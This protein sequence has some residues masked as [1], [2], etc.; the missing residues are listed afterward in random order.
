MKR[1]FYKIMI[2]C[3][4]LVLLFTLRPPF[5]YAETSDVEEND[6][7]NSETTEEIADISSPVSVDIEV[8]D[9]NEMELVAENEYLELYFDHKNAEF[10]VKEK[11]NGH[12]WYSNPAGRAD[13]PIANPENKSLM[14]A[15]LAVQFF[16]N[17][18]QSAQFD[19]YKDSVTRDQ[20]T[21]ERIENGFEVVYEIGKESQN[22]D[23]IPQKISKERFESLILDKLSEEE[24][25]DIKKRFKYIEEE[26]LYERRDNAFSKLTLERTLD[27]FEKAGYTEEDVAYDNEEHGAELDEE[28]TD[29]SFIIPMRVEI[30]N[31]DLVV[32]I[33]GEKIEYEE[34]FPI[35]ELKVLPFFGAAGTDQE[36]YMLVP[37]GSGALI[38]LNNGKGRYDQFSQ[39]IYGRDEVDPITQSSRRTVSEAIRM[40]VFGMKQDNHAFFAVIEEGDA[41]G[42]I[43]AEVSGNIHSYN[44]ISSSFIIKQSQEITLYG[45]DQSNT[46]Y[47]IQKGEFND[48]IKIRYSF[49]ENEEANYTGMA[50]HYRQYLVD[51]YNLEPLN[52]KSMPFYLELTGA[53]IK[54]KS[55]LGV[56]YRALHPLTTFEQGEEIVNEL[57]GAN[58]DN[59]K[60]RYTGWFNRGVNH[61]IPT[62][63]KVDRVLGGEKGLEQ[64]NEFLV[65]NNL[66]LY[67]D[68]AFSIVYRNSFG[69]SPTRHASRFISREVAE[70]TPINPATFRRNSERSP[71][72]LLS[73]NHLARSIEG[74]IGDYKKL[75]IDHLSLRD[76]GEKIN[77]DYRESKVISREQSKLIF[78]EQLSYIH[79]NVSNL[80]GNGGNAILFPYAKDIINA[81][82]TS[83]YFNITD[84]TI[85]F[86]QIVLHGYINYAGEP[87]NLSVDQNIKHHILKSL[88][89]GSNIYFS[90]FYEDGSAIKD[91]E[92]DHLFS[93][94]YKLWLDDAIEMYEEVNDILKEVQGK[95][96]TSH[97]EL[98]RGVFETVYGD[99]L[100]IIVNYNDTDVNINGITIEA[101]SYTIR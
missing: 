62:S 89:T 49:L 47:A 55:L 68:A 78:E 21:F 91:T 25:N 98:S 81:P 73:P 50:K 95:S 2:Y 26:E 29:P 22:I 52:Q 70:R 99:N 82:T 30:E 71:Y 16:N 40:P 4:L 58:I 96:I 97:K 85:P 65:S 74:F 86:Y 94:N 59:I 93:A 67:P 31:D 6:A 13:D 66:E 46:V 15:Q 41:L 39:R 14:S 38:E 61:K 57:L 35:Y 80:M 36:G 24:R 11:R 19:T 90:W 88:E 64:F 79:D 27:Y 9:I 5:G 18:G 37:D 32:S 17:K 69:F 100:T 34:L 84:K 72:Y 83:S 45:G 48:K 87:I 3:S 51:K 10:A 56:P 60:V 12:I 76:L 44:S 54:R 1:K 43:N 92:Y 77:A 28:A 23:Q 101:E 20:F 8:T 33:D 63:I 42:V 53:I 7:E 75:N